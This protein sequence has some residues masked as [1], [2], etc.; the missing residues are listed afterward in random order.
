MTK[1]VITLEDIGDEIHV[2]G[3]VDPPEAAALPPTEALVIGTYLSANLEKVIADAHTWVAW[4]QIKA[5]GGESKEAEIVEV[6]PKIIL[7]Q[8]AK[9]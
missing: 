7:P 5:S 9:Q 2:T 4:Q 6:N 1:V 3:I 8:G